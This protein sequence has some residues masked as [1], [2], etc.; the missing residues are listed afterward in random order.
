MKYPDLPLT[1]S[2][3]LVRIP[4]G[5]YLV[6]V[7]GHCR[8]MDRSQGYKIYRINIQFIA[9]IRREYPSLDRNE[10]FEYFVSKSLEPEAL[11][12][13]LCADGQD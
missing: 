6:L 13:V 3:T 10:R 5:P 12:L 11:F 8:L 4:P 7:Q 1:C 9:L 2:R